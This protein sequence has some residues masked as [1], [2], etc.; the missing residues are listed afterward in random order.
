VPS[1]SVATSL[2]LD[3]S[4]VLRGARVMGNLLVKNII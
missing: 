3:K 1:I 2:I 4:A